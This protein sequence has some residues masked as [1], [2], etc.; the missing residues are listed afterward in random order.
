MKKRI[1]FVL[2]I[3]TFLLTSCLTTGSGLRRDIVS[4]PD[5]I[6]GTYDLIL[7]GGV[8]AN[9]PDRIVIYDIPGDGYEFKPITEP[10]DQRIE[11]G[12]DLFAC[13]QIRQ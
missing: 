3:L 13:H 10:S 4:E 9:D 7:I 2:V 6:S 12:K 11:T 1:A 8:H 5:K